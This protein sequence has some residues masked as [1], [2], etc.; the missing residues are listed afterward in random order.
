M[1]SRALAATVAQSAIDTSPTT[2]DQIGPTRA[3]S[4]LATLWRMVNVK[5]VPARRT[6]ILNQKTGL[7]YCPKAVAITAGIPVTTSVR[8][9]PISQGCA[10]RAIGATGWRVRTP[11]SSRRSTISSA[12][13]KTTMPSRWTTLTPGPMY[14]PHVSPKYGRPAIHSN[15]GSNDMRRGLLLV[16]QPAVRDQSSEHQ[17]AGPHD[18]P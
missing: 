7:L 8:K 17:G 9:P 14:D 3:S 4:A 13:K 16:R 18:E 5:M 15:S 1:M 10:S 11:P 6:Y 2:F 12:P